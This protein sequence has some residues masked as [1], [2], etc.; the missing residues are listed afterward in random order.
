MKKIMVLL[1]AS[2]IANPIH[3]KIDWKDIKDIGYVGGAAAI[4]IIGASIASN[5]WH[6]ASLERARVEAAQEDKRAKAQKEIEEKRII[7]QEE[8]ER[9]KASIAF[10]KLRQDYV[11]EVDALHDKTGLDR[12]RLSNIVKSKQSIYSSRFK[13]YYQTLNADINMLHTLGVLLNP[14]EKAAQIHLVTKLEEIKHIFNLKLNEEINAEQ[15]EARRL[16]RQEESERRHAERE[17]L[18]LQARRGEVEAQ[19]NIKK[20]SE[21]TQ[22]ILQKLDTIDQRVAAAQKNQEFEASAQRKQINLLADLFKETVGAARAQLAALFIQRF[23][24]AKREV[25]AAQAQAAAPQ[26]I[27]QQVPPPYNPAAVSV[28]HPA[29]SEAIDAMPLPNQSPTYT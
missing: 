13:D 11:Q 17:E 25:V 24:N 6:P 3:A 27:V 22:V 28:P 12:N 4:G 1:S 19:K 16:K 5:Y 23:D 21:A 20:I 9:T 15:E 8:K 18:E 7:E 10:A 14:A 26:V 2:L 29:P